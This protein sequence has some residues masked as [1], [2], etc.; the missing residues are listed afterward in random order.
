MCGPHLVI[1]CGL[2]IWKFENSSTCCIILPHTVCAIA[3][4][5]SLLTAIC[6]YLN[7]T[8]PQLYASGRVT[9][10]LMAI[11]IRLNNTLPQL[12]ASGRVTIL[13]MAICNCLNNTLP[14]LR[15]VARIIPLIT[16]SE[17]SSKSDLVYFK[18]H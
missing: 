13:L 16:W 3:R 2:E 15:A 5:T 6:I 14:H 10:P 9:L 11:C 17:S 8:L 12:C 7:N 18:H 1:V 4:G